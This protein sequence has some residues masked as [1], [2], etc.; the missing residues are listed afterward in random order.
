MIIAVA[1]MLALG[2]LMG[3]LLAVADSKLAVEVDERVD[4][5]TK[6][7]PGANC[8]GC[9]YPGCANFAEGLVTGEVSKVSLCNVAK[10]EEHQ[11]IVDY[12]NETPGPDGEIS[13][14]S[15]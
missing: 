6:M 9:G 13:K 4:Q 8:G 7:L 11:A 3:L 12:L 10:K 2:S 5:V 1:I 15:V 14:V